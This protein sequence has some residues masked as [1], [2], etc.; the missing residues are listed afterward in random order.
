MNYACI[1]SRISNKKTTPLKFTT[2]DSSDRQIYE[3]QMYCKTNKF[4]IVKIINDTV[5]A[6]TDS[7]SKSI[8]E[9][10]KSLPDQ[11]NLIFYR[12]D[13]FCRNLEILN[14]LIKIVID[15]KII[16]HSVSEG[17]LNLSNPND[18]HLFVNYVSLANLESEKISERQKLRYKY[19]PSEKKIDILKNNILFDKLKLCH[20]DISV[21]SVFIAG[22]TIADTI[23]NLKEDGMTN[24][25]V[26][27]FLNEKNIFYKVEKWTEN[28]IKH[29][30]EED[31]T[32]LTGKKRKHTERVESEGKKYIKNN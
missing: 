23:K 18:K 12:T 4:E 16:L 22:E 29:F 9:H 31:T 10:I 17:K 26:S 2:S 32:T 27:D 11:I 24:K 21:K 5:S 15:K 13:R 30:V 19:T 3:C 7:G 8:M 28:K 1:Y 25:N 20:D 6:F 14:D